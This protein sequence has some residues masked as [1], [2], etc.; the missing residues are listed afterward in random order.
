MQIAF[1]LSEGLTKSEALRDI[2]K[3]NF[4][5]ELA[6]FEY[7]PRTGKADV[8]TRSFPAFPEPEPESDLSK[9]LNEQFDGINAIRT[10]LE[11]DR[12]NLEAR[13]AQVLRKE[14]LL[15]EREKETEAGE[16]QLQKQR[17]RFEADLK[18]AAQGG[19]LTRL[20]SI[21]HRQT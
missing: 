10:A 16:L 9:A 14:N 5:G 12:D 13:E 4:R 3:E 2:L 15:A 19:L 1:Q 20:K 6:G 17:E 21:F 8:T 18:R 11:R 7:D